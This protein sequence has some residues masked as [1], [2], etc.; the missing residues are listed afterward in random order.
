MKKRLILALFINSLI[1]SCC[2][3]SSNHLAVIENGNSN[4]TT[5]YYMGST[6]NHH[7]F[8]VGGSPHSPKNGY[9][10]KISRQQ[11][12][13]T[14]TTPYS[15][16]YDQWT[17]YNATTLRAKVNNNRNVTIS[18]GYR[19]RKVHRWSRPIQPRIIKE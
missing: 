10:Y 13:M 19:N 18:T 12:H 8:W 6:A 17:H 3:Y 9:E 16:H 11:Y 14:H 2:F 4:G 5:S 1:S 15:P 7:H